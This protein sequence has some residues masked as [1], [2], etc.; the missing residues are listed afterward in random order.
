MDGHSHSSPAKADIVVLW[1]AGGMTCTC[2]THGPDRTESCLVV[3]G[4]IVERQVFGDVEVAAHFA[5]DKMHVY[6]G[7]PQRRS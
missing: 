7:L 4:A 2:R 5:L 6:D 1:H 3:A